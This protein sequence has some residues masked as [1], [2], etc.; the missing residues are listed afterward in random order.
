MINSLFNK[1]SS[2]IECL[3]D[4]W[5]VLKKENFTSLGEL[6]FILVYLPRVHPPNPHMKKDATLAHDL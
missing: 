1:C 2:D 4:E 3:L 5:V 6:I